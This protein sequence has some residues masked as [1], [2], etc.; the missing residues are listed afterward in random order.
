MA[1]LIACVFGFSHECDLFFITLLCTFEPVSFK[2]VPES[3]KVNPDVVVKIVSHRRPTIT[4]TFL[5][6][7]VFN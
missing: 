3:A 5:F 2:E 4:R 7:I 6:M 1:V